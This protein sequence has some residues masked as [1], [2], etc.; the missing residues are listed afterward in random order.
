LDFG[1]HFVKV[2][3][4]MKTKMKTKHFGEWATEYFHTH[5]GKVPRKIPKIDP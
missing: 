4:K 1:F 5:S 3:T 2:E